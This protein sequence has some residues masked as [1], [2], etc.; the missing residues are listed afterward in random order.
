MRIEDLYF[1]WSMAEIIHLHN[2]TVF[3]ESNVN[4]HIIQLCIVY[5][6]IN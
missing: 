4:V 5:Q 6:N 1:F 3:V 2:D